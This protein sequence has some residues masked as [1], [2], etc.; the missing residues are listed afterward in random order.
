MKW[1]HMIKVPARRQVWLTSSA[2]RPL[3]RIGVESP[4]TEP[5]RRC[6]QHLEAVDLLP[7]LERSA[8]GLFGLRVLGRGEHRLREF[9]SRGSVSGVL[10]WTAW[11][12]IFESG[13]SLR[14]ETYEVQSMNEPA[15]ISEENKGCCRPCRQIDRTCCNNL[16]PIRARSM[17]RKIGHR[18]N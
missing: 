10:R 12:W 11:S 4:L 9:P 8:P 2:R 14:I 13:D 15:M 16:E 3:R 17:T 5:V 1:K 18:R 7:L 6:P